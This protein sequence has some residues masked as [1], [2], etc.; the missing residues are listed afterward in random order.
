MDASTRRA[1]Q[2]PV[3]ALKAVAAQCIVLHHFAWYGP[4][5]EQAAQLGPALAALI[6]GF[7]AY[8]RYA[9]A[10]FLV[11]GG[12]LSALA[13][14]PPGQ[15]FARPVAQL[16]LERYLRLV[17]PFAVALLCAIACNLL[18]RQ[19]MS[20]ESLGSPP[21]LLQFLA[22]LLL[23]HSLLGV[24]SLSTGVWYVAID[25]QLYALF[26]L[27]LWLGQRRPCRPASAEFRFPAA[28]VLAVLIG[29][30]SLFH[31]NRDDGWDATPFYFFGAYSLGIAA[32]WAQ[33]SERY[34][35]W[36]RGL[37]V[38]L[39]LALWVDFRDRLAVAGATAILLSSRSALVPP[40]AAASFAYLGRTSYALFLVHFPMYQLVG[41]VFARA[42]WVAPA[43]GLWGI[44]LAWCLSLLAADQLHRQVE[45]PFERW[46]KGR[47]SS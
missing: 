7:A 21:Q 12:Y 8:G 25:L 23:L 47:P 14:P 42:G 43:H 32:G 41:G 4:L 46:R 17:V 13:L 1:R 29:L 31:F 6:G 38:A 34:R 45:Q 37:L 22:H 3:D 39:A 26:V 30:A 33:R 20:H 18:V 9:V 16:I 27:L 28:G 40:G 36:L 19:W 15:S 2:L 11:V 24:E 44:V 10:V 35:P 5:S